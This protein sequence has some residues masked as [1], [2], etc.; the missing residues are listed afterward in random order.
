VRLTPNA[1]R[2]QDTVQLLSA[3]HLAVIEAGHAQGDLEF[4]FRH[5][6]LAAFGYRTMFEQFMV[7][8][9]RAVANYLI[10]RA[11]GSVG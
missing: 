8:E 3:V 6:P 7:G 11:Q 5:R 9:G 2:V 4:F 10:P 1:T